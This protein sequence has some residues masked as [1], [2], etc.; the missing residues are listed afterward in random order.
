MLR[1]TVRPR[2]E[3]VLTPGQHEVEVKYHD[4]VAYSVGTTKLTQRFE[5]GRRYT[6][7]VDR[8]GGRIYYRITAQ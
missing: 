3:L 4:S 8:R 7:V 6:L 1:P 5:Q 2:I